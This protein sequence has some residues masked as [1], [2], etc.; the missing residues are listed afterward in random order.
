MLTQ[1]VQSHMQ[2]AWA[3]LRFAEEADTLSTKHPVQP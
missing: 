1:Y 2:K 3:S